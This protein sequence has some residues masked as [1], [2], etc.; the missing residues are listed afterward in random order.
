MKLRIIAIIRTA[1]VVARVTTVYTI[2]HVIVMM[3]LLEQTANKLTIAL[4]RTV[5]IVV[6]VITVVT[7]M[8]VNVTVVIL[9]QTVKKLIFAITRTVLVTAHVTTNSQRTN[10]HVLRDTQVL[11]VSILTVTIINA[12]IMQRVSMETPNILVSVH[13]D[14]W[15]IYVKRGI[16]VITRNAPDLV[17]VKMEH[18]ATHVH[19][20]MGM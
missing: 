15:V 20:M 5:Q 11:T 18:L 17:H 12:K 2:I 16:F 3:V 7:I 1:Q 9:E 13:Q 6:G 14:I 10:V 8:S 19:V 4:T